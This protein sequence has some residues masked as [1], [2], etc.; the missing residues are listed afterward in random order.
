[1]SI[2]LLNFILIGGVGRQMNCMQ[3]KI[4][5]CEMVKF[6]CVIYYLLD[7]EGYFYLF[8]FCLSSFMIKQVFTFIYRGLF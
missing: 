7:L 1:M 6:V 2:K 8:S 5:I 3:I 4:Y